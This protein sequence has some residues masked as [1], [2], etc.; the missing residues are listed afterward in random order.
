MKVLVTGGAGFIGSHLV[1][2]LLTRNDRVLVI[3]NYTTGRRDNLTPHPS[4]TVVEGSITDRDLVDRVFGDFAPERV[5]HAAASYKDPDNW[6]EDSRTNVVGTA[7]VV[8]AS[9]AA[10]VGRLI[11]FQTALCY[12]LQPL[13]QPITLDHPLQPQGSSYAISKTAGEYYVRLSGLDWVS[14]RLANACRSLGLQLA[15]FST[16]LVFDGNARRPYVESDAPNP[17]CSRWR[18]PDPR[19]ST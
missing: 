4:L 1:D 17:P 13:E 5:V 14:L 7:N 12:G 10:G 8:Q 16:D 3:D 18:R 2:R 15:T 11:Y 6:A 9:K 19:R